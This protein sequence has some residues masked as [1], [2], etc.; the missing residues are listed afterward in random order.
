MRLADEVYQQARAL[1]ARR[2]GLHFAEGRHTNLE[3]GLLKACHAAS[4]PRLET[5]L[6][7]LMTLPT[8]SQ[9]WRRLA[10]ALMVG[11]TYFFRDRASLAAL[12]QYVLPS[13]IA[14][15]R[16]MGSLQLRIWSAGCAT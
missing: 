5:Y 6:A 7:W 9:E 11:E 12:E 8:A 13:L 14:A 2:L 4:V 3:R 1:I 10:G 15:Q 16:A